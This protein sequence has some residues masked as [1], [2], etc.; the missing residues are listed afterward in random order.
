MSQGCP[1][2]TAAEIDLMDPVVQENWFEAY[3]VLRAESPVYFMPQLG[4]YVLTRYEDIEYVL[5]RP[6]LFSGGP[7]IQDVE[8]LVKFPE[9]RALYDEKGWTRYT[10]LSENLPMHRRYRAL[11]DPKLSA[12]E[13]R[14]REPFVRGVINELIDTWI[15]QGE[16]EF[17]KAFAEPLPMIVIAELLGFPRMDLPKLKVWSAAWVLPFSRGLT[18]E[19]ELDA[20]EK[21]IELQHYI[22]DAMQH[23]RKQPG[24]DILSHLLQVEMADAETGEHRKLTDTEIIGITDH[25]LIGGNE[26]TA[27]AI[28]NGLWLLFRH[29]EM[30]AALRADPARIKNFVEETL[31]IESPTQGLFRYVSE[32]TELA[33]VPLPKGAMLSIRYGAGNHDPARFPDSNQPDLARK[34]AGR[35]LAFGLG[36]RVCPGATLSRLEQNWAWEILL[37][38]IAT[39]HPVPEKDTYE[40]IK[41]MWM[42]ALGQIHLRFEVA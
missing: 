16:I 14:R 42:R 31:R 27:F 20:V 26:T 3:D 10:P 30:Q 11:V 28:A 18:L 8:P 17:M 33:G 7:D 4:M 15:D 34:N 6:K 21:H 23:K 24:D 29:P 9:A 32:D 2:R 40:H 22:H 5:R 41:G 1:Y 36:E 39:F 38:R 35:H 12:A 19:Q 13:I 25:L 37:E